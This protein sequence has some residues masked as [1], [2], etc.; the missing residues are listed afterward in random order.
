MNRAL[1]G[2]ATGDIEAAQWEWAEATDPL[3]FWQVAHFESWRTR[4]QG[5]VAE[6]RAL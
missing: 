6:S 3:G 1:V 4:E 2:L 5:L